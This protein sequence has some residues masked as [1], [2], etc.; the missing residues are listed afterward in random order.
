MMQ[1]VIDALRNYN[2][3]AALCTSM[4][5]KAEFT[6]KCNPFNVTFITK[7]MRIFIVATHF[8]CTYYLTYLN[9]F[10]SFQTQQKDYLST[11]IIQIWNLDRSF[12]KSIS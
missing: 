12:I 9:G 6:G 8:I 2:E 7:L 5:S 4:K 10:A 1:R 3:K 11:I